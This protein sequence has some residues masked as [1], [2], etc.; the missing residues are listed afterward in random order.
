MALLSRCDCTECIKCGIIKRCTV[1]KTL[2]QVH[3]MCLQRTINT[4][5]ARHYHSCHLTPDTKHK[6]T[7]YNSATYSHCLDYV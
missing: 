2:C 5:R 4:K 7:L 1:Q 3:T 6:E